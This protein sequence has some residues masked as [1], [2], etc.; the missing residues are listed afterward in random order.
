MTDTTNSPSAP[1]A[2][3][4]RVAGLP[5]DEVRALRC[6]DSRRWA[7]DVLDTTE[8][9]ALLAGKAADQLHG[10]IGGSDDEPLR[11]A[12]LKLRR[13]VFNNR[14]PDPAAAE[15]ALNR[16]RA[17]DPAAA[18]ALADWLTGR[19]ALAGK[20]G[21]GAAL[22]ADET[23]RTRTELARIAGHE[24]LRRGL[25]LASPT[26]DAQLDAYREKASRPGARPDRKQRKI[27]R[28]LL[29]YV[30]RTACKTSPFSTFTGVAPGVFGGSDGLR[31]RVGEEWRT[32][33]RLNVV[34]LGRIADAVIADPVRRADLPLA[35]ASGWGRDDDRVR[36]VR[37]WVTT[38]DEDAAVTFDAVK[39]RLFFLRRS[40]TLER[41]LGLFEERGTI[42]YGELAAW[43]ERD[44]GA[45]RE[46]CEQYLG[47]LLDVGMVQVP[48]LRTEVHDTD[49]LR[50]F[51][52]ALRGL[53]RPWAARLA[54]RLEEPAAH[55]ARFADAAPD[56]RRVLLAAVRAGLRAVQEEE[57]GVE[58]AKVPQT[59]LYEDAAAGT[60]RA[61]DRGDRAPGVAGKG[62]QAARDQAPEAPG[63]GSLGDQAPGDQ[64]PEAPA[65]G[66]SPY[67]QEP[68][69]QAPGGSPDD[70]APGDRASGGAAPAA[71]GQSSP[72]DRAPDAPAPRVALDPDAWRELAAGPLAAVERVLPAF[73]LTLPQRI[74][75][76]GFFLARYGHGGRCDDLLKLVHDFHEDFFDQYMTFTASRTPYDADGTY[77]PEVNWLG[78]P[79]L[80]ALDDARR[81]FTARMAALWEAAEPDAGE[82]WLDDA[83]LDAVAGELD[84]PR[85]GFAPMSHHVQI[86]DRPG[87]PLVVLNRSY[88]GV[89]FSF[90][91]FTQL[92]DGLDEQLLADAD[93][94]VPEGAVLA[95]V[96]GGPVTSNLNL[97]GRLTPYEIVCPGERGTLGEEFRIDLDDL[98][99]VHDPEADRLALRSVRLDREVI[100][101]YLGY[102]V[103][104][105]LPELPRTLLL[106]SPTSMAPLNVWAGVPEGEPRG[107]VTGR[108][109]VRHGSLVLSRRSWSAPAAVLPLHRPGAPEDGWF[110]DWH[111]F[112]RT[113][114]L[115]DRVFATVSD[116]GARGAT[117]AKPQYLDFDSPLSLSAFEALIKSPDARVVF[118][119]MLPD[120]DALP[121]VSGPGRHVAELAVETAVPVRRRTTS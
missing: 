30:Y 105:A 100:P 7:D 73:D 5:V 21:A 96:T 97:H 35:L 88:G 102:L 70:Q 15:D 6:P 12:L 115:P 119:E 83:F 48:C 46:E 19:R 4:L 110:L 117:G 27:E 66:S 1:P 63:Q 56:E 109:R 52:D 113:H 75:F 94:L 59:L 60:G 10:L 120:E 90:T 76:Q 36:Y 87:D 85:A 72:G 77:V 43:L 25:L 81:T 51:Q 34:A 107:G 28:S 62:A 89:S 64:A 18:G 38:G 50:A 55:A 67:D 11:R 71:P 91:R 114:G 31:T 80:R 116:T 29:S 95:E 82:V 106:L 101:V 103:P 65:P 92:F 121:T 22:L 24:R 13:D 118:R 3:M 16:V 108:P 37:R 2:F 33:V 111:A 39:D 78:L 86:A 68:D 41:L 79:R 84:V 23:G 14:L 99:L 69:D 57:L 17:L 98:Y 26:L 93:A 53:D 58:R 32:Q 40:G 20:R 112:R 47:A 44:R 104:L 49:P 61:P 8:Q 45:A 74:T 9:L 54:D 42:R